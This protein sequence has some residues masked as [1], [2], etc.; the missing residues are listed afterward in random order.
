MG[1]KKTRS[2]TSSKGERRSVA[3]GVKEVSQGRSQVDKMLNKIRAWKEG[4]NPWVT[5]AG[6][7]SKERFVRVRAN[8]YW[9]D[10]RKVSM[11]YGRED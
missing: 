10:P 5:V 1:K 7:S 4:K 11:F 8:S 6:P 3:A 9:G 2:S